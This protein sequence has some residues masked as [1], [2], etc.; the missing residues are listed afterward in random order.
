MDW[1]KGLADRG[2]IKERGLPL[3]RAGAVVRA[4]NTT[5]GPYVEKDIVIGYTLIEAKDLVEASEASRGC[6]ILEGGGAVEV[7]PVANM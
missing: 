4:K 1:M 2:Y 5:D 6:P 7:R 3:E